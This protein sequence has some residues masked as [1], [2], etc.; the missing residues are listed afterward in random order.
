MDC[1][2]A[3]ELLPWLA[4]DTL[5][6]DERK[7]ALAHLAACEACRLEYLQTRS[8]LEIFGQ[9]LTA[10]VLLD[11]AEGRESTGSSAEIAD[12]HLAFCR[13]C[14]GDLK[15][16]GEGL[17]ALEAGAST[18]APDRA[19]STIVPLPRPAATQVWWKSAALAASI[20]AAVSIGGWINSER[21]A[22][23]AA[24][25]SLV[26][27][28]LNVPVVDLF[29]G[30]LTVRGSESFT[31]APV[32]SRAGSR[33]VLILN[34]RAA[35]EAT[36]PRLELRTAA[37]DVVWTFDGLKSGPG[38]DFTLILPLTDLEPDAYA[39]VLLGHRAGKP[40]TLETF[41]LR[42]EAE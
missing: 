3:I 25:G 21:H 42:V 8:A 10:D 2:G 18:A 36:S 35:L 33:A 23:T 20:V 38:G 13:Q 17:E 30:D 4:N 29:P 12:Q 26:A 39:L 28:T 24:D 27:P 11:L 32:L 15:A 41:P 19:D 6:T 34:S 14:A 1:K 7:E 22:T 16:L 40:V 37:G 9:H 31:R 5:E